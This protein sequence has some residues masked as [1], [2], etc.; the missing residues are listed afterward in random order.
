[1]KKSDFFGKKICTFF[2]NPSGIVSDSR[3]KCAKGGGE[4]A[5][6]VSRG[7][8]CWKTFYLKFYPF[9]TFFDHW[10]K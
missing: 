8:F 7:S 1:M 10:L 4:I 9:T 2:S 5:S 3:V 6:H